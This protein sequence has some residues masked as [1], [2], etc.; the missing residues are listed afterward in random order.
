VS[1][2]TLN[3][4]LLSMFDQSGADEYACVYALN[5]VSSN[6]CLYATIG[7]LGDAIADIDGDTLGGTAYTISDEAAAERLMTSYANISLV[8]NLAASRLSKQFGWGPE[9]YETFLTACASR[10]SQ[11]CDDDARM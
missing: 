11:A 7:S 8:A 1:H 10:L 9:K 6:R 4:Q 2:R 5:D 3:S